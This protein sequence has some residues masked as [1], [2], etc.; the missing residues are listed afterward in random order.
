MRSYLEDRPQFLACARCGQRTRRTSANQRYCPP[1]RQRRGVRFPTR[2]K[3]A[4]Y[5]G[6]YPKR[7]A[8]VRAAAYADPNTRCWRCGRT[9]AQ[10]PRH[11]SGRPASWQAGHIY[12]GDPNSPLAPEASTCNTLAGQR[13]GQQRSSVSRTAPAWALRRQDNPHPCPVCGATVRWQEQTCCSRACSNQ[14]RALRRG[15][16]TPTPKPV[17]IQICPLCGAQHLCRGRFCSSACQRESN[18]RLARD[19]YRTKV[20]LPVD[21]NKPTRPRTR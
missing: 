14:W 13:L 7:S 15:R 20:G 12:D 18:A 11:K 5:K 4:H 16:P 17:V 1:C 19:R 6:D 3:P 9:L 2:P 8:A 10:H 21:P